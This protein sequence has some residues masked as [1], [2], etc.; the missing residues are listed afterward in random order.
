MSEEEGE[1]RKKKG[2]GEGGS[3]DDGTGVEFTHPASSACWW[4][5][6]LG[7]VTHPSRRGGEGERG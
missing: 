6:R 2:R 1:D 7:S 4:H 5:A 3:E